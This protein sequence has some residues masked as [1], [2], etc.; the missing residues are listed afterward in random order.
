MAQST[1]REVRRRLGAW[2]K[3][4]YLRIREPVGYL[5]V[6]L[7]VVGGIFSNQKL[8]FGA[9]GILSGIILRLLFEIYARADS[10]SPPIRRFKSLADARGEMEACLL[11]SLKQDGFIRI[12]WM[13]MTMYNVWNTMEP[14]FDW[15]AKEIHARQVRFE[16][17]MLD[18]A[19]LD[20]YR[21][22]QSWTGP[23]ATIN[24]EKIQLYTQGDPD[25]LQGLEWVFEV[26]RYAH[27]PVLHGGLVNGKYLFMG[28]CRWEGRTLKAGDRPFDIYT[29]KDGDD[30]LDKIK[31]FENWFNLC[32]GPKPDWYPPK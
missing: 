12:Q 23:S 10:T 15:L 14:V 22:N 2:I 32:F 13:G 17:A 6:I 26:H 3:Q 21:I 4:A 16:V 25:K 29:F 1:N 24:A 9:L 11:T 19:W 20:Q 28:I 18:S 27:M 31:V 8:Q 30:A 5:L 7:A